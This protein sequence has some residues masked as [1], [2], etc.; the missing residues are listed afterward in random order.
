MYLR[1]AALHFDARSGQR[2][3]VLRTTGALFATLDLLREEQDE[4][5]EIC[6][7]F[8]RHLIAPSIRAP[9]AIFWFKSDAKDC[10]RTP[11]KMTSALWSA[12]RSL[13]H[14]GAG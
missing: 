6:F 2:R 3:G 8:N 14:W 13:I 4:I 1:F 9:K 7:W 11:N 12:S 10:L 5:D